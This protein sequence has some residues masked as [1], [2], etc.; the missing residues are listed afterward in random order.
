MTKNDSPELICYRFARE[1]RASL[2]RL[3]RNNLRYSEDLDGLK[4]TIGGKRS[5]ETVVD[6]PDLPVEL[7]VAR[8]SARDVYVALRE[9]RAEQGDAVKVMPADIVERLR[10][11]KPHVDPS[12][13]T[14]NHALRDL[15][16]RELVWSHLERGWL[17]GR[18]QGVLFSAGHSDRPSPEPVVRS[19]SAPPAKQHIWVPAEQGDYGLVVV[20]PLTEEAVAVTDG[21][22]EIQFESRSGRI[23]TS[24]AARVELVKLDG[25]Y[26]VVK[27]AGQ[28]IR[29]R[30]L[31]DW[32]I[33]GLTAP[34]EI[35][36]V[37][38]Q[39]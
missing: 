13:D 26:A 32:Q 18:A 24:P 25:K 9:L 5:N 2:R 8:Q 36:A 3:G 31:G 38:S 6:S 23:K 22:G 4:I 11:L 35:E 21:V 27:I 19:R 37:T 14:V 39:A 16:D 34:E 29:T 30:V 7:R 12:R 1:I 28:E 20:D 15:K 10:Q 17:I 33:R